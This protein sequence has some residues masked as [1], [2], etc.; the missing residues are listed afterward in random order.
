VR[1][2]PFRFSQGL[3]WLDVRSEATGETFQF[4]LDSGAG[5]TILDTR[6]ARR[7]NLD[8][9]RSETVQS[10]MGRTKGW[11]VRD[12]ALTVGGCPLPDSALVVNLNAVERT[13]G[14]RLDGLIGI[15]FFEEH[16]V[17]LDY[18]TG[19]ARIFDR[20]VPQSRAIVIPLRSRNS[21]LC[22][23]LDLN[24]VR[25]QWLRVDTGCSEA[26]HWAGKSAQRIRNRTNT[27]V[28]LKSG[29]VSFHDVTVL[30][31]GKR[32]GTV[33]AGLHANRFFEGEN[34]LLGNGLLSRYRVTIDARNRRLILE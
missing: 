3:V 12:T 18:R 1:E 6:C 17:Q 15:D 13:L 11:S 26:V 19:R 28:A 8:R 32:L 16:A 25:S 31:E 10:V 9:G 33:R 4:L 24:D 21:I 5:A 27:T 20:Y 22:A 2:F 30:W 23:K 34:G 7:L 14:T 29:S